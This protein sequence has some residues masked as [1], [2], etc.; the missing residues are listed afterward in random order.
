MQAV[1]ILGRHCHDGYDG[2]LAIMAR[3]VARIRYF[4]TDWPLPANDNGD[5]DLVDN[6]GETL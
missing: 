5:D 2:A 6:N 3:H 4:L 1:D